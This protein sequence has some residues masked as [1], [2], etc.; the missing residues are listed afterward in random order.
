[1]HIK[2]LEVRQPRETRGR[3]WEQTTF[4]LEV[5]E[6]DAGEDGGVQLV[7]RELK[8][9]APEGMTRGREMDEQVVEARVVGLGKRW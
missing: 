6:L 2:V 5:R 8:H 4:K 7:G 9:E 1:M 3:V